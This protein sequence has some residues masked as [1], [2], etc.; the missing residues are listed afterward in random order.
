M[1]RCRCSNYLLA[2]V[3]ALTFTS[4]AASRALSQGTYPDRPI[5]IVVPFGPGGGVDVMARMFAEKAQ[6]RLGVAVIVENRAGASGTIGGLSVQQSPP[7]G[8]TLL[9]APLTHVMANL[10]MSKVP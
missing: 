4:L 7:D 1:L 6:P 8:Y 10:V 9:F 3:L 2:T 5:R